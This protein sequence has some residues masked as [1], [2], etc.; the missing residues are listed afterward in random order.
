MTETWMWRKIKAGLAPLMVD[1]TRIENTAGAGMPDVNCCHNG[2]EFW[3]E[4]KIV[5]EGR[6]QLRSSQVAWITAR[7]GHGGRA[8]ILAKHGEDLLVYRGNQVYN[9]AMANGYINKVAAAKVFVGPW[10][11]K[12]ILDFLENDA[13]QM[14]VTYNG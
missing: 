12:L 9:L 7:A 8:F 13:V 1:L 11:W 5:R 6:V 10:D 4:L 2:I 14:N 3:I